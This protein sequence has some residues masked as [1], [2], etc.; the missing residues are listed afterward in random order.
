MSGDGLMPYRATV[1]L[2]VSGKS[3][4]PG[5]TAT[6]P[7]GSVTR[8]LEGLGGINYRKRT[9][10]MNLMFGLML[11]VKC[12]G[13]TAMMGDLMNRSGIPVFLTKSGAVDGLSL[14][15]DGTRFSGGDQNLKWDFKLQR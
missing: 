14:S 15:E 4:F 9:F 13:A 6:L 5:C 10:N 3:Q 7:G 8:D 2:S 11:D 1:K 12:T